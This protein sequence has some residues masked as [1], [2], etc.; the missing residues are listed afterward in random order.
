MTDEN[1]EI[2]K[3]TTDQPKEETK[4]EPKKKVVKKVPSKKVSKPMI[5]IDEFIEVIK[6]QKDLPNAQAQGF[7]AYMHGD[8]YK[9]SLNDFVPYLDKYLG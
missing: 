2:K 4:K 9:P 8:H 5:H 7:K 1:K 6:L 3:D